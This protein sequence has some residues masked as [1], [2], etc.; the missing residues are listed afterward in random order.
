[1]KKFCVFSKLAC[2]VHSFSRCNAENPAGLRAVAGVLHI[3]IC[4]IRKR[5]SSKFSEVSVLTSS[6]LFAQYFYTI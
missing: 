5:E 3:L 2:Y 1:M 4:F 6:M